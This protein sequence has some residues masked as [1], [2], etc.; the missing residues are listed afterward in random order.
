VPVP[1]SPQTQV[2]I[3]SN[4]YG[5]A[6]PSPASPPAQP[7]F[8]ASPPRPDRQMWWIAGG[9]IGAAVLIG[10]GIAVYSKQRVGGVDGPD[11]LDVNDE[12]DEGAG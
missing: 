10:V 9:A 8:P 6:Y 7:G 2:P 3:P 5:T 4:P 11:I 1:P 12:E